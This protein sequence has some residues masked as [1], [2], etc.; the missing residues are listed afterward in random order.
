VSIPETVYFN[1]S[2]GYWWIIW[3]S[4]LLAPCMIVATV[5]DSGEL[6]MIH[7]IFSYKFPV[8]RKA[9]T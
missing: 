8:H 4:A 3:L 6:L 9:S 5:Q 2:S 7:I 1:I